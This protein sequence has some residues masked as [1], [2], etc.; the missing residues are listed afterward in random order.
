MANV[1]QRHEMDA[2]C[3]KLATKLSWQ[4]CTSK[5]ANFQLLHLH[6]TYPT[7]IWRLRSIFQPGV[8]S[9]RM[10]LLGHP[11]ILTNAIKNVVGD[12]LHDSTLVHQCALQHKTQQPR[13]KPHWLKGLAS[14][15]AVWKNQAQISELWQSSNTDFEWKYA[16]SVLCVLPD[17]TKAVARWG[18]KINGFWLPDF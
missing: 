8:K 9:Q 3:D 18:G 4:C 16:I 6:L 5:V 15:T 10:V 11:K 1:L 14:H 12:N 7:C 17:S 2:Q 13:D